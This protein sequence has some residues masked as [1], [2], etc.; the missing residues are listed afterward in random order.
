MTEYASP[1]ALIKVAVD[2][3]DLVLPSGALVRV[4]GLSRGEVF[5]LQKCKA[6]GGIKDEAGWERRMVSL[7]LLAPKLTEDQV[8]N[9]QD[10]PA[11]GDLEELTLKIKE[12]SKL[13]EGAD[14]SGV[15][16]AGDDS[17]AGV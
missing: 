11:G 6:D 8:G 7:A 2:E 15:P 4:R 5:M 17:G 14:K 9:W 12:L 10:G 16:G 3:E 13:G 1:E